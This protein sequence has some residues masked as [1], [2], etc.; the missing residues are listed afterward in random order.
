MFCPDLAY[1]NYSV[2]A[3]WL[4]SNFSFVYRRAQNP[5][6]KPTNLSH[7]HPCIADVKASGYLCPLPALLWSPLHS[8]P[9]H[10]PSGEEED[11]T[12]AARLQG[13]MHEEAPSKL[14]SSLF[15]SPL[16]IK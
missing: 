4:V 9:H 5:Q 2:A 7:S 10:S 15:S 14:H 6:K 11:E 3:W 1:S 8:V 12:A 16:S 13:Q